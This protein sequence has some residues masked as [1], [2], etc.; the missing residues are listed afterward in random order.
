NIAFNLDD[1]IMIL[2]NDVIDIL[3]NRFLDA[4]IINWFI[5]DLYNK[6]DKLKYL[7]TSQSVPNIVCFD[8]TSWVRYY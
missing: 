8:A 6:N 2:A 4:Q 3:W 5:W 1:R 7:L